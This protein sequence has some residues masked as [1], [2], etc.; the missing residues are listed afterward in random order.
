VGGQQLKSQQIH[1]VMYTRKREVASTIAIID[2]MTIDRCWLPSFA[3]RD[4][5]LFFLLRENSLEIFNKK[6][7]SFR[8]KKKPSHLF[9]FQLVIS[10]C[11][12]VVIMCAESLISTI[13]VSDSSRLNLHDPRFWFLGGHI[14]YIFFF[15]PRLQIDP[16]FILCCTCTI[17]IW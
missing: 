6:R 2:S 17:S 9:N 11:Q 16:H 15:L 3:A 14:N 4:L 1:F 5:C 7:R 12:L 10:G 8:S 13:L